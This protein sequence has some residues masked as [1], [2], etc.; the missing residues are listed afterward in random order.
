MKFK[1]RK[2]EVPSYEV[3]SLVMLCHIVEGEFLELSGCRDGWL[4]SWREKER[5]SVLFNGVAHI[6]M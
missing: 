1:N 5:Q 3:I 6:Y 2:N 4:D